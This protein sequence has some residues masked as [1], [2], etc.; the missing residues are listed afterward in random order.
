[1]AVGKYADHLHLARQSRQMERAGRTVGTQALWDR[2]F[3][4]WRHLQPTYEA[5][6]AYVLSAPVVGADETT[7]R[8]MGK[9]GSGRW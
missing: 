2:L 3:A 9:Q 1:M 6:R 7:W 5:L 8:L 4:L